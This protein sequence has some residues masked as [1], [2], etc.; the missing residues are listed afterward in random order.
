MMSPSPVAPQAPAPSR[1]AAA[2]CNAPSPTRPGSSSP[3]RWCWLPRPWSRDAVESGERDG[4]VH[5]SCCAHTAV[6]ALAER[7]MSCTGEGHSRTAAARCSPSSLAACVDKYRRARYSR[8]SRV[9]KAG[10][11]TYPNAPAIR[12]FLDVLRSSYVLL[13]KTP[14]PLDFKE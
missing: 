9:S 5:R 12:N 10:A 2:A 8:Y 1:V 14:K 4:V 3:S 6:R 11:T 7:T 13:P